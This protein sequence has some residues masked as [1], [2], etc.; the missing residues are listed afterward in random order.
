MRTAI[1]IAVVLFGYSE[2]FFKCRRNN[3]ADCNQQTTTSAWDVVPTL[4]PIL[5]LKPILTLE[6]ICANVCNNCHGPGTTAKPQD[7]VDGLVNGVLLGGSD[8]GAVSGL[9]KGT[10]AEC[11]GGVGV[12]LTKHQACLFPCILELNLLN[13]CNIDAI[14]S[15]LT[16][17]C[18]NFEYHALC[19]EACACCGDDN[20]PLD[21]CVEVCLTHSKGKKD[22][23]QLPIVGNA[24]P[25][26]NLLP[27]DI[28]Q[29]LPGANIATGNSNSNSNSNSNNDNNSG[30]KDNGGL[31]GGLGNVLGGIL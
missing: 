23:V 11:L 17:F 19:A 8:G 14:V 5:D 26:T 29:G 21:V 12:P 1:V 18:P 27:Q 28:I 10:P 25:G 30:D 20:Q 22:G 16:A 4:R 2:A 24:L 13:L 3:T 7:F 6:G 15:K 9:L 31:L